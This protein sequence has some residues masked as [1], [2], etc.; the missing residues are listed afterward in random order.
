MPR[1]SKLGYVALNVSDLARAR[2]FYETLWGLGVTE[3]GAGGEVYLR[4]S[5]DHHNVVLYPAPAEPGLKRIGW[6]MESEDE[7]DALAQRLT[8]R[9]IPVR[10]LDAAER[11]VL[12]Q[13]RTMRFSEPYTGVTHEYY[14][15][16][17]SFG[18]QPFVPTVAKIQRLGHVVVK[19]PKFDE[20]VDFYLNVLNFRNSDTVE[21][22]VTFMRC[23]PNP[24]HH[25]FGIANSKQRGLHHVNFMV[26]EVDDIGRGLWRFKANDV[27]VVR[28]PGRHPPSGSMFLYVLDPD[29]L[30]V[31][32]SFGMEEFPE[33][34]A[35]KPRLFA[36]IPESLDYW[37]CPRDP[38]Q[39]AVGAV[40]TE[41]IAMGAP[42]R[43]AAVP[44]AAVPS[45][46]EGALPAR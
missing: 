16:M 9:G 22:A 46:L 30:T 45:L 40:E 37:N 11:A 14:V 5:D 17:R 44:P 7:L 18:G 29:A 28:G 41:V 1:Y 10:E 2:H 15:E 27:E 20:A 8:Q 35:R 36:P 12:H 4:C 38:R 23:F 42:A 26:T 34:N 32:Y 21:N 33:H 19:T 25:S 43:A 31:E 13:G 39:G 6:E 3:T 24:F